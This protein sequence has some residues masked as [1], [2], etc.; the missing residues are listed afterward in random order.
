MILSLTTWHPR[1]ARREDLLTALARSR[2]IH[3]R[4]GAR[5]MVWKGVVGGATP[6]EVTYALE[7]DDL[8]GY[9]AFAERL[10]RD[11]DWLAHSEAME[12]DDVGRPVSTS[13]VTEIDLG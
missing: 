9:G 10:G 13:L 7:F 5:V 8:A 1:P 12:R 2:R 6:D 11:A 4:L 3:E